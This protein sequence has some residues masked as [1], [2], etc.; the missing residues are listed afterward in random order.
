MPDGFVGQSIILP[1]TR[2]FF[3]PVPFVVKDIHPDGSGLIAGL[4]GQ[5]ALYGG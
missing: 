4:D 2:E 5:A 3:D 1:I